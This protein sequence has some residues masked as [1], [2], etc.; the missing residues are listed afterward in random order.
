MENRT[1]HRV[2]PNQTNTP[3]Q[4]QKKKP[5]MRYLQCWD[6][7]SLFFKL[8]WTDS[9]LT[10]VKSRKMGYISKCEYANSVADENISSNCVF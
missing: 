6:A 5:Y 1:A 9:T 4:N 8:V 2:S 7:G 3:Q 10:V